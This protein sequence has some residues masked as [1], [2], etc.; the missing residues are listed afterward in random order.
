MTGR[1]LLLGVGMTALALLP[2]RAVAQPGA[3]GYDFVTI[4]APGNRGYDGPDPNNRVTGRG[5][6][7]YEYRIGRTEVTTG[8]WL[9][10]FNAAL[11]RPDPLPFVA[12]GQF[13][14]GTPV[15]WGAT[16]DLSYTGPG[17]RYRLRTDVPNAAMLPVDGISWRMAALL[18]NWLHNDKASVQSAFMNGAYDVST[19]TPEIA[20]PTFNDQAVHHAGA[21]Y[22][23]PTLDEWMKAVHYDAAFNGGL[24]RWWHQPNGTDTVLI[25]GPPP[26][27]G[28]DGTAQA[29]ANYS[30]PSNA[31]RTIPLGAYPTVQSPWGLLD[32]AGATG[33]WLEDIRIVDGNMSRLFEG[34]VWGQITGPGPDTAW[35]YNAGFAHSRSDG[36]RIASSVPGPS[37][38][39]VFVL[40]GGMCVR[41]SRQ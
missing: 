25:Y 23:V 4:G 37:S 7:S 27:H 10:F 40:V 3:D 12:G 34:S 14:W 2:G 9:E 29:N 11:A 28:G 35:G 6:V 30:L 26:S 20:F 17:V 16:R 8:Q 24:G 18:C 21:R 41:R 19:F 33:E 22:W 36:F 5:S 39:L 31:H 38:V 32:A 13:W 15:F 1:G